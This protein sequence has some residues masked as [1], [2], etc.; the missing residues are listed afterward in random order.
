[1]KTVTIIIYEGCWAMSVFSS[2]DFF[3]VVELLEEHTNNNND[4]TVKLASFN[5]KPIK[6]ASGSMIYPDCGIDKIKNSDLVIIPPIEGNKLKKAIIGFSELVNWIK[7]QIRLKVPT[8]ALTT[9]VVFL[10]ETGLMSGKLLATHWAFQKYL[11]KQYPK[12]RFTTS[13]SYIQSDAIYTTSSLNANM[14]VLLSI[15][16]NDKGDHFAQLCATHLLLAPVELINPVLPNHRNHEDRS[17]HK[18]QEWIEANYKKQISND[19]LAIEFGFSERNLKR[20]FKLATGISLKQY[21]QKVRVDKAKKLLISTKQTIDE[22]AYAVG[23]EN[24]NFFIKLFKKH[25]NKT[26]SQWRKTY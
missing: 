9:G 13:N 11:Q 14:D 2:K 23:Y 19:A 8:I 25:Q 5:G 26:P 10:A 4:Y 7:G 1:M 20:R 24:S 21:L 15:L 18:V 17:I 16:T 12:F 6:S 3:R 22:I